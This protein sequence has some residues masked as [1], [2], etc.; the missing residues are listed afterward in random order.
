MPPGVT[1]TGHDDYDAPI[2]MK[3]MLEHYEPGMKGCIEA[4]Q[5]AG[6][7]IWVPTGWWHMVLNVEQTI[8][9]TQNL[10]NSRNWPDVWPEVLLDKP[11]ARE[12][13][14]KLYPLR[15]EL[16]PEGTDKVIE[17]ELQ[18]RRLKKQKKK[19]KKKERKDGKGKKK[20]SSGKSEKKKSKSE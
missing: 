15:P 1:K 2:P 3:W 19:E 5:R 18:E 17:R 16:F 12:L 8:A 14:Q 11:M 20:K 9:V 13:R 4:T 6:E 7:I 10:C